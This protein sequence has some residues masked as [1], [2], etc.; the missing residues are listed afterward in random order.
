MCASGV[1]RRRMEVVA[2]ELRVR[3]CLGHHDGRPAM[4]TS[5]IGHLGAALELV[6]DAVEGGQPCGD[7]VVVVART[8]EACDRAKHAAGLLAP[9]H[10]ATGA[11]RPL[12]LRL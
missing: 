1:D 4:P 3:K 7:Q 11:E 6:D 2:D 12:D 10:P 9:C 5:D 8:E